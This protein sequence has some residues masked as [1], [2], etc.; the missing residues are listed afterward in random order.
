[1]A[2]LEERKLGVQVINA[3]RR[4]VYLSPHLDDVALSCGG[5]IARQVAAGEA[6]LVV[7]VFAGDPDLARLSP[8]AR[9]MHDSW[10][11]PPQ[12]YA[13]RR[14][15]DRAAMRRLG[16]PFLHLGFP[17]ALYRLDAGGEPLYSDDKM[18][19]GQLH[20]ADDAL[21][22]RL[23][24]ALRPIV[25]GLDP[26]VLYA[27][28][29]VGRHVDHQLV[30]GAALRLLSPPET[31]PMLWCYEDFP[32]AAERFPRHAPDT[33]PAA[34]TR[35]GGAGWESK[36]VAIDPALK[37]EAIACYGSQR[38]LLFGDEES[39]VREVHDYAA[40]LS[41]AQPHSERFWRPSK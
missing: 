32:Y 10:G 34:L 27:P 33:V 2:L 29:A 7:T 9:E 41:T 8:F 35:H 15:E 22:D 26:T 31:A 38:A 36:D 6:V 5:T 37:I 30:T 28:L 40:A 16:V 11:N 24:A 18:L 17:D 14:A 1:M 19:F 39:M 12:P 25:C 3:Y 4:H 20:P 13:T 21:V 23:E